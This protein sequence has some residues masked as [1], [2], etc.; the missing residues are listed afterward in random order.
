MF[1][2]FQLFGFDSG[3][4]IGFFGWGNVGRYSGLLLLGLALPH[5]LL[6]ARRNLRLFGT[7]GIA[8]GITCLVGQESFFGGLLVTGAVITA[9]LLSGSVQRRDL[10]SPLLAVG[11][12]W[13]SV[14]LPLL[15]MYLAHGDLGPF[16]R[17]YFLYPLAVANGFSNTT[18][19]Q[20]GPWHT[21]YLV[22]PAFTLVCGLI[23]VGRL[24]PIEIVRRWNRERGVLF[25][26]FA[27]AAVAQAGAFLRPIRPTCST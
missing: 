4:Y 15:L 9:L 26:C 12:G 20:G 6:T 14:V 10:R 17:N 19:W 2:T 24:R 16:V 5:L 3:G 22:L 1:P 7:L 23:A 8:W 18:W 13:A 21:T 27:A 25:G 11:A